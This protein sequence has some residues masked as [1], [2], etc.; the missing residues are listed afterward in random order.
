[1]LHLENTIRESIF[2]LPLSLDGHGLA[3]KTAMTEM[4]ASDAHVSQPFM[5]A[6]LSIGPHGEVNGAH[7]KLGLR[8]RVL[9]SG[10][11]LSGFDFTR[12]R[13]GFGV[14]L[15]SGMNVDS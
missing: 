1:M 10:H 7:D 3:A 13:C 11:V 4:I 9:A 14:S 5:R 12:D 2:D 6:G 15:A 8:Q